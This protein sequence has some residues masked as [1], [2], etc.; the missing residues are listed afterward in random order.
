MTD[1]LKELSDILYPIQGEKEGIVLSIINR[2]QPHLGF[3]II[4]QTKERV[5]AIHTKF[6]ETFGLQNK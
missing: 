5:L 3:I 2:I 6:I 1:L 4:G